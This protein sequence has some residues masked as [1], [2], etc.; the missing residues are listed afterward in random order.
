MNKFTESKKKYVHIER[1]EMKSIARSVFWLQQHFLSSYSQ[2]SRIIAHSK[3][4]MT[5][6][7]FY[8]CRLVMVILTMLI[9]S[10]TIDLIWSLS[11]SGILPPNWIYW[12]QRRPMK[13]MSV[14]F[15]RRPVYQLM[16]RTV[17]SSSTVTWHLQFH[18]CYNVAAQ[19]SRREYTVNQ[20][21]KKFILYTVYHPRIIFRP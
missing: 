19:R 13:C 15:A 11:N 10:P 8:V 17:K 18:A 9:E 20:I 7:L 14:T 1:C 12:E 16:H 21:L 4:W 3:P 2:L 5:C 6:T